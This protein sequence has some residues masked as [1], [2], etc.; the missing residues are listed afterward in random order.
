[1]PSDPDIR[2]IRPGDADAW[3]RLRTA[4]WPDGVSDHPHEIAAFFAHTIAEPMAVFVAE[5]SGQCVAILELAIRTDL[6]ELP[7]QEVGYIEGLYIIPEFRGQ[8]LAKLLLRT[9]QSW[10]RQQHCTAFASDRAGRIILD[11]HYRP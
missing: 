1:M 4:M 9:A 6:P 8:H 10:A 11:P 5:T 2:P 7:N 3:L